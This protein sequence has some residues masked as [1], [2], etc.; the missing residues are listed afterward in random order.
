[1]LRRWLNLVGERAGGGR[2]GQA[3]QYEESPDRGILPENPLP[4]PDFAA[5][6][7][8]AS[9]SRNA[10][11]D[12]SHVRAD[13]LRS[14]QRQDFGPLEGPREPRMDAAQ[15]YPD[16]AALET[17]DDLGERM[18]AGRVH[19]RH[20]PEPDDDRRDVE[21]RTLNGA[22]ELLGGAE[23]ERPV[24]AVDEHGRRQRLMLWIRRLLLDAHRVSHAPHEKERRDHDADVDRDYEVD[25]Y[26]Q[27]ES[28]QQDQLVRSRSAA[29][30]ARDVAQVAH[31][32]GNEE[33]YRRESRQRDVCG[34]GRKQQ[35]DEDQEQYVHDA[36][37]RTGRAVAD[38]G[39]G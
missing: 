39:R 2:T 6:P 30:Q 38:A 19:E 14:H 1:M 7:D 11:R 26:R 13:V 4:R 23:E 3:S 31:A 35:D 12:L 17:L 28:D 9:G 18:R 24:D 36:R 16:A 10:P 22:F 32:P 27:R 20:P 33:Q 21:L 34:P 5:A 25:E 15:E 29:Q 8:T 37:E